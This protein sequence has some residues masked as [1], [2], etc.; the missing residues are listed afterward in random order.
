[1]SKGLITFLGAAFLMVGL[2]GFAA[3]GLMGAHL[4]VAHNLIHIVSGFAALAFGIFASVRSA[5]YFAL[6]FGLVYGFLGLIGL[7]ADPG[8]ASMPA[9]GYD[10]HLLVVI[11]NVLELGVRDAFLHIAVGAAFILAFIVP[12]STIT[13][14]EIKSTTEAPKTPTQV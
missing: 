13:K 4:S 7:N 6:V 12:Q 1:M 3:P 5:K 11:P 14:F 10:E 2:V 9:M 8:V